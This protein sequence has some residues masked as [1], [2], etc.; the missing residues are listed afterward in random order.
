MNC[1]SATS[2]GGWSGAI[3]P[4]DDRSYRGTH[5][6]RREAG[7]EAEFMTIIWFDP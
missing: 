5:L 4:P 1:C 7:D 3:D 6:L 2:S